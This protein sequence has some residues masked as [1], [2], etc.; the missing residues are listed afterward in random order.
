M[1]VLRKYWMPL[2]FLSPL[3]SL[4]LLSAP[5]LV[6][7]VAVTCG[8]CESP[9]VAQATEPAHDLRIVLFHG[10]IHKASSARFRKTL[11]E[12][13]A[14]A[15]LIELYSMGGETEA[16]E[17]IMDSLRTAD[18]PVRVSMHCG[19]NCVR[20]FVSV[21]KARRITTPDAVFWFHHGSQ[22]YP[23]QDCRW[24]GAATTIDSARDAVFAKLGFSS[25][26]PLEMLAWAKEISPKLPKFLEDCDAFAPSPG[27]ALTQ[28]E[29]EDIDAGAPGPSCDTLWKRGESW[30]HNAVVGRSIPNLPSTLQSL[31]RPGGHHEQEFLMPGSGNSRK[32]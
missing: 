11:E 28:R 16:T 17:T 20:L 6:C 4:L 9:P 23:H 15:R 21:P 18:L 14:T 7:I 2:L 3:L 26:N 10:A 19:S 12:A 31:S 30:A 25:F 32:T 13:G 22:I 5:R 27:V 24:C 1:G 29:I 8:N